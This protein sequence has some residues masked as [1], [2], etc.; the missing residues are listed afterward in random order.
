VRRFFFARRARVLV[1]AAVLAVG[2]FAAWPLISIDSLSSQTQGNMDGWHPIGAENDEQMALFKS[3]ICSCGCP[4]E[5][6]GTCNCDFADATRKDLK[7]QLAAGMSVADIQANYA[8]RFGPQALAVPP[9]TGA[10]WL[11]WATPLTAIVLG[12]FG[13]AFMIRKWQRRATE[14][15][16]EIPGSIA[17]EYDDKLDRELEE[18]DRK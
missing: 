12:A 2:I 16:E 1:R 10:N 13:V 6:L 4:R 8:K 5:T 14:S 9:N 18:L 15:P 7:A 17:D 11:I 3:L